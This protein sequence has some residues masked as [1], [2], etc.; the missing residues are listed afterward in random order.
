MLVRRALII[1]SALLFPLVLSAGP[2]SAQS[3]SDVLGRDQSGSTSGADPTPTSGADPARSSGADA[4]ATAA[5]LPHTGPTNA[6]PLTE[7]ATV[8]MIGGGTLLVLGTRRRR[9]AR[10]GPTVA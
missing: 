2:A 9:T 8:L 5:S 4:A 6:V 7:A 3:Y 10:R 1:G